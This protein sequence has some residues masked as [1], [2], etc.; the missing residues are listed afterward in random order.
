MSVRP[1]ALQLQTEWHWVW[2]SVAD[3]GAVDDG[4]PCCS[5]DL[6][7]AMHWRNWV[8]TLGSDTVAGGSRS[9]VAL[10]CSG[11]W[12]IH[13]EVRWLLGWAVVLH[14]IFL[15]CW[16]WT[17]S[18]SSNDRM[19]PLEWRAVE[20]WALLWADAIECRSLRVPRRNERRSTFLMELAPV[21]MWSSPWRWFP[22]EVWEGRRWERQSLRG[23][24]SGG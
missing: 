15:L 19:V 3:D 10:C 21:E 24:N 4:C 17:F 23:A 14:W 6:G 1:E 11:C 20:V 13:G 8:G 18:C 7:M 22:I 9:A 5:D 16:N 2:L 12:S